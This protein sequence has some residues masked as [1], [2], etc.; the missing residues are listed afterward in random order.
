MWEGWYILQFL[1]LMGKGRTDMAHINVQKSVKY[2]I[3]KLTRIIQRPLSFNASTMG[4]AKYN[5]WIIWVIYRIT[6][7]TEGIIPLGNHP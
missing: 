3:D 5:D 1:M 4:E 6:F 7:S 2:S